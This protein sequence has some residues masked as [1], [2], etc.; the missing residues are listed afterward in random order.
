[1]SAVPG[2]HALLAMTA[3]LLVAG[4]AITWTGQ[5]LAVRRRRAA[6]LA[7]VLVAEAAHRDAVK[8]G[9]A[10]PQPRHQRTGGNTPSDTTV[11]ARPGRHGA[12]H[13]RWRAWNLVSTQPL[14]SEALERA[15]AGI[16]DPE[17]SRG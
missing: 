2:L 15:L 14:D 6:V 8:R 12:H 10:G 13:S 11:L 7:A 3:T 17:V 16:E 1:M 5:R 4:T 9:N